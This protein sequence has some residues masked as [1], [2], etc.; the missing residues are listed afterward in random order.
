MAEI[1][2]ITSINPFTFEAQSYSSQDEAL[3]TSIDVLEKPNLK[4]DDFSFVG[5]VISKKERS[6]IVFS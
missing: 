3:I 6:L 1:V 5:W 4:M 2:N